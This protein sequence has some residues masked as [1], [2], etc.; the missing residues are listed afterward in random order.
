MVTWGVKECVMDLAAVKNEKNH[1]AN[2][3]RSRMPPEEAFGNVVQI[4]RHRSQFSDAHVAKWLA[5]C[6]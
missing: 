5:S 2:I 1:P 4:L 3:V 6:W